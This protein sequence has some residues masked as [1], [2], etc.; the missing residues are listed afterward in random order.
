MKI[1]EQ[2]G[3]LEA[4]HDITVKDVGAQEA[5]DGEGHQ[6]NEEGHQD[7][8]EDSGKQAANNGHDNGDEDVVMNEAD[9]TKQQMKVDNG[10]ETITA[11]PHVA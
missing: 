6:E 10:E 4:P 7:G 8:N 9:D 5:K 11:K 2:H 1:A 3:K